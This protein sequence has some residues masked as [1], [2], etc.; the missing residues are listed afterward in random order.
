MQWI[1]NYV[2]IA[3]EFEDL[4]QSPLVM[5]RHI[6]RDGQAFGDCDDMAM[7]TASLL[8]SMGAETKLVAEFPQTDG[9][10]AHVICRYRFPHQD[11][12]NDLDASMGLRWREHVY[13]GPTM[14]VDI[15]S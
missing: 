10:Y 8:A 14:E 15:I 1:C 12:F 7:L 13:H 9:S 6:D 5:L 11:Y 3:D 2:S 4:L